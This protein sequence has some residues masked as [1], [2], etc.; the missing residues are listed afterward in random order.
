V[1]RRLPR[2]GAPAV[3]HA[4]IALALASL[5]GAAAS[6]A[7]SPVAYAP[8]AAA[9]ARPSTPAQRLER[10]FLQITAANLRFQAEASRLA[11]ARSNNPSVR[12]LANTLATRQQAMQ[13]ELLRLL[14]T[15]G[16]ALPIMTSRQVKVL[17]QLG[18]LQGAKFDQLYVEEVV[19]RS[20]RD[21]IANY[22]RLEKDAQDPVLKAWI[23]RQLPTLRFQQAKAGKAL[24]NASLRGQRAV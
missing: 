21:D 8:A 16:M 20:H 9:D 17:K 12:D 11:D 18:K 13:P 19:L 3:R 5:A 22:E 1:T 15:R 4:I 23:E 14:H 6:A 7:P 24:P 2:Q 10:L